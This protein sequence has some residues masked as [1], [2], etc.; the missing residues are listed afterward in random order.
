MKIGEGHFIKNKY[1][2]TTNLVIWVATTLASL[3]SQSNY[4]FNEIKERYIKRMDNSWQTMVNIV[5]FQ[6]VLVNAL[7]FPFPLFPNLI[8]KNESQEIY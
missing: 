8:W 5:T 6:A 2:N 1:F 3:A 7:V 4:F